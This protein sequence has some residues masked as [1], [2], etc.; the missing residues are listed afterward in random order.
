MNRKSWQILVLSIVLAFT[1]AC[2][3]NITENNKVAIGN[4]LTSTPEVLRGLTWTR[5]F[6]IDNPVSGS[7]YSWQTIF[8]N[9]EPAGT[10]AI[11]R[12]HL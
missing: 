1:V 7:H 2:T 11:G 10:F 9:K 5:Q 8:T 3:E 12:A 6:T 4:R